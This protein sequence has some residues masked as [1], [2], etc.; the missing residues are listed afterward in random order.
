MPAWALVV[1]INRTSARQNLGTG[2]GMVC[3]PLLYRKIVS[4]E[5]AQN[6]K[7]TSPFRMCTFAFV[8]SLITLEM[9]CYVRLH[10]LHTAQLR[11]HSQSCAGV[12]HLWRSDSLCKGLA[13]RGSVQIS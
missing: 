1:H 8:L 4:A 11:S 6:R 10:R 2:P 7:Q 3:K 5:K 9:G 12:T 13:H